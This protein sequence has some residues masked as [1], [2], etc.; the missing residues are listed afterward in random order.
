M[1]NPFD[2]IIAP[3]P[4]QAVRRSIADNPFGDDDLLGISEPSHARAESSSSH[5]GK[6]TQQQGFALDPFF[7][8]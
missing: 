3:Q 1:S 8:E 5:G 4:R 6:Q 2:D 7:D